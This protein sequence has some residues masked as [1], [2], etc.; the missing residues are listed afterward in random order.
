MPPEAIATALLPANEG[1]LGKHYWGNILKADRCF[2]NGYI[3][4]FA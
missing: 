2:I 1:V 4:Y 3:E